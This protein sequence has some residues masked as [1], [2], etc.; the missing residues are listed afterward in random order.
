MNIR[1][2]PLSFRFPVKQSGEKEI[3][4]QI[5]IGNGPSLIN[6][7]AVDHFRL[8]EREAEEAEHAA[9]KEIVIIK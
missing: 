9:L 5:P 3:E 4:V 8:S 1:I 6:P 2:I 7:D